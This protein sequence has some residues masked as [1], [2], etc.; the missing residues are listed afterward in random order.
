WTG[1][2]V[3]TTPDRATTD[4]D[5]VCGLWRKAGFK[6]SRES[7]ISLPVWLQALPWGYNWHID[8]AVEGIQR[9]QSVT[10]LNAATAAICQ[11]DWSGNGP[12]I[13]KGAGGE[14]Y[15]YANGLLLTSR[16]GQMACI[17]IF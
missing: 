4:V 16:R 8:K 10:S 7:Y 2:N 6:A 17:D 12:M 1:I 13:K 3:I 14:K 9:S 15:A 5:Y 11:G